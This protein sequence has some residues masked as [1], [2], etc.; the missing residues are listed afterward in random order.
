MQSWNLRCHL[1]HPVDDVRDQVLAVLSARADI[2][3]ATGLR[4][5]GR[6]ALHEVRHTSGLVQAQEEL[7][8]R[9]QP[10]R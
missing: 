9:A 2:T 10:K 4:R 3:L 5:L 7:G 6:G 8:T 1:D